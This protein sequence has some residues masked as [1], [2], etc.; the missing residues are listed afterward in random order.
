MNNTTANSTWVLPRW[1]RPWEEF[2][3]TPAD[4][5]L[6]ALIRVSCG[7]LVTYTLVIYGF[8]LQEFM[9][10]HAWHDMIVRMDTVRERPVQAMPLSGFDYV[11]APKPKDDFER[12]YREKYLQ[13]YGFVPPAPYPSNDVEF[14][15]LDDFY[16]EFHVDVRLAGLGIPKTADEKAYA[17]D[18]TRRW[19]VPPP[20]YPKSK[21]EE[22]AIDEYMRRQRY[23]PRSLYA[24][25]MPVFSLWFHV[26][27]PQAMMTIHCLFVAAC[28]MFTLGFCTRLTTA[29]TWFAN[30]C[31]I[32][33]NPT[34][35]FGADTMF[36]ILLLYLMI[37]PCGEVFSLDRV[38]RRWWSKAKPGFV[39]GWFRRL[40]KPIPSAD[41]IA[42]VAF[43]E[44]PQPSV[45]AN[46]TIRLLQIHVCIIY[47]MSGLSKLLGPAWWNGTAIW[48]TIA[49]YEL[50]PM[51]T[52][53]Y[54]DFLRFLGN[55]PFVSWVFLTG[56][57]L[58]T[59][60]FE[61]GYAFLVWRPSLRWLFLASAIL[62]HG[63]IGVFM[64]L[65]TFSLI[66][67]VMN[68]AFLRKEE[69]LWL[70]N[71]IGMRPQALASPTMAARSPE[72]AVGAA[73]K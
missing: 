67:L 47:L 17:E 38:I 22:R 7:V 28:V 55:Y 34:I 40:N 66:M 51:Q 24:V 29:I 44:T 45:S 1:L 2:W 37:S 41:E 69:V 52:G 27:D 9:G 42:P 26:L 4:A 23:D 18:Y 70:F 58:F 71:R 72:P 65:A 53:I 48:N 35:L 39:Q 25:G 3:F 33:R 61:I 6:W 32:H 50:A 11:R 8:T 68:M 14:K 15:Y 16:G 56:G 30:L 73:A 43:S 13:L 10:E 57:G 31:Y 64:G 12:Q 21:E 60:A 19:R 49:N 46:V 62:L 5:T 20:A 59:L 36:T 54:L 63:L